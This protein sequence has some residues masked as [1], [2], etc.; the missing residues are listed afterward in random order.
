MRVFVCVPQKDRLGE[1]ERE[2]NVGVC[3]AGRWTRR[4]R[5]RERERESGRGYPRKM[6]SGLSVQYA[7]TGDALIILGML[8]RRV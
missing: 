1:R 8:K 4:E 6:D 2:R 5:E 7:E 3:T